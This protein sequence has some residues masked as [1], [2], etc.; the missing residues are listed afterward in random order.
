MNQLHHLLRRD[1]LYSKRTGLDRSDPLDLAGADRL[2]D[3]VDRI[4]G[5]VRSDPSNVYSNKDA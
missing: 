1:P 5:Q 4:R 2:A 3:P